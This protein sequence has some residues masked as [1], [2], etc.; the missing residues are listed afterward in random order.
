MAPQVPQPPQDENPG[1]PN[2]SDWVR[3][4]RAALPK[5]GTDVPKLGSRFCFEELGAAFGQ[6]EE[7]DLIDAME[8]VFHDSPEVASVAGR[9]KAILAQGNSGKRWSRREAKD[10]W[11]A[12]VREGSGRLREDGMAALEFS[13]RMA[14]FSGEDGE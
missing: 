1:D 11:K 10:A 3:R 12:T 4:T 14:Y 9:V 8:E 5:R 13:M 2:W 6:M 7:S